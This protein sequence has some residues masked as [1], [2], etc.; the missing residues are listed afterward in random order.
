MFL[1][2]ER[3]R[4]AKFEESSR[5]DRIKAD[6]D[7][8]FDERQAEYKKRIAEIENM[9]PEELAAEAAKIPTI[10]SLGNEVAGLTVDEIS[11]RTVRSHSSVKAYLKFH[12]LSAKDYDPK[13]EEATPKPTDPNVPKRTRGPNK[14]KAGAGAGKKESDTKA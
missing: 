7:K 1:R 14:P 12:K 2:S 10:K 11:R 13:T 8:Q 6:Y 5:I 9:T 3:R 4:Q